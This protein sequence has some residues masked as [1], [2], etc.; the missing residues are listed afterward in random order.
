[1]RTVNMHEAKTR[2]SELVGSVETGAETEIVI[3]RNGK[4]AARL[5]PLAEPRVDVS[6]RLG[7]AEGKFGEFDYEAFQ[8][9]DE[10]IWKGFDPPEPE[11]PARRGTKAGRKAPA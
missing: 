7:L 4:P 3:A 5:V 1:M 11:R 10:E 2:L 8:A 6:K 9:L